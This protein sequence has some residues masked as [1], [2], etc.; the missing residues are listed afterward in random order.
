M[1]LLIRHDERAQGA[2]RDVGEC[3]GLAE[4]RVVPEGTA[5]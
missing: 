4:R 2:N 3:N 5:G 1:Y